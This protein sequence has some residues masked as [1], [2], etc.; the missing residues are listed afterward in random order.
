[1]CGVIVV[2]RLLGF[3]HRFMGDGKC[4]E[5]VAGGCPSGGVTVISYVSA[6][7]AR[8]LPTTLKVGGKSIGVVGGTKTVVSRPF[9]DIIQDLLITVCRLNIGRIVV[10]NRASYNTGRV[11]DRR[12]VRMVGGHNVP[13]RRVSVVH[14]YNVSFGS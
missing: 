7:L 2:S 10:I 8:L 1:M 5:F 13:S 3:G 6:H 4:R 11:S 12:V 9:K 14:C